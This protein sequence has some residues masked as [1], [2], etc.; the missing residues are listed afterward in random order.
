ML[1]PKLSVILCTRNRGCYLLN[2]LKTYENISTTLSWEL[3]I[4]DNASTDETRQILNKFASNTDICV[5]VIS[6]PKV[7]LS[8]ARNAGWQYAKSEVIIFSDDDCYP[9]SDFIDAIWSNFTENWVDYIGGRILLYDPKD[10]PITI[11]LREDR[12]DLPPGSFIESGL[13]QGANMAFRRKVLLRV[14]G[15]DEFLGAGTN[16]PGSDDTDIINR[17]SAVG[18]WGAYDPRPVVFH[19]HRRQTQE[20]V[21]TLMR[22]YDIGRGAYYMKATLDKTRRSQ[23]SRQWYWRTVIPA[24][25]SRRGAQKL[26]YEMM[27]AIRYLICQVRN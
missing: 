10:F 22:S 18:F 4:V 13:I 23:V 5:H 3:I 7:G 25:R 15:F 2:T 17:A 19:H 27:G 1:S 16:L 12:Y 20:Q 26:F 11:Q 24:L 9:Q 14:G 21:A 6:E 8:R